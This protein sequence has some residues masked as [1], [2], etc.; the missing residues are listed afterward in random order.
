M[1]N[2]VLHEATS[3]GNGPVDAGIKAVQRIVGNKYAIHEFNLHGINSGS[4]DLS[5]AFIEINSDELKFRGFASST[6]VVKA[7]INAYIDALNKAI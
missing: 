2:G 3:L 7:S 6:D 4:D 1:I 5:K